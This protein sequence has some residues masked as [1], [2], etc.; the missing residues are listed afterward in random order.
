M[1]ISQYVGIN[2]HTNGRQKRHTDENK[3]TWTFAIKQTCSKKLTEIKQQQTSAVSKICFTCKMLII[4]QVYL[5]NV[6]NGNASF[7]INPVVKFGSL[8]FL[9]PDD[10][11]CCRHSKNTCGAWNT[12]GSGF[13]EILFYHIYLYFVKLFVAS[14]SAVL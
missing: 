13:P 11:L 4:C 9:F 3:L 7:R 10:I 12:S 14:S 6:P 2:S 8:F 5:V 1:V